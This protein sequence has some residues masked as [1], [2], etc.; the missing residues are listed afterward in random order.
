[1]EKA[2]ICLLIDNVVRNSSVLA[3]LAHDRTEPRQMGKKLPVV[4][5]VL[6]GV[7]LWQVWQAHHITKTGVGERDR[8]YKESTQ[9]YMRGWGPYC[10]PNI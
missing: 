2:S 9:L 7:A 8:M 6:Y 5:K 4:H 10:M 1:M 3:I